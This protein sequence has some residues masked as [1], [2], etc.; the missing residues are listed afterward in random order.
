MTKTGVKHYPYTKKG[1]TAAKKA[2]ADA[3]AKSGGFKGFLSRL[4]GKK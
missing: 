2:K 3:G 1:K 4:K